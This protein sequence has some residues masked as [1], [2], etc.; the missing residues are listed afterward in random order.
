[1]PGEDG[2]AKRQVKEGL[3]ALERCLDFALRALCS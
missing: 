1:M 3:E 2:R